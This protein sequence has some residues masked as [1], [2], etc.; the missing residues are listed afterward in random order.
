MQADAK[1]KN[2]AVAGVLALVAGPLGFLYIGWRYA[3]A[4]T[5]VF[6]SFLLVFAILL[7]APPWFKYVNLPAFAFMAYRICERL[8]G[9]VDRGQHRAA[10]EADTW[11][12]AVFAMTSMLPRLAAFD[13]A[14]FGVATAIPRLINGDIGGSLLMLLLV[15]PLFVVVNFVFFVVIATGI[16]RVVM[17]S[18]PAAPRYIF[19]P[20]IALG[21]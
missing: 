19:P 10:L 11:P 4:A 6:L 16:D 5:V 18:V 7:F 9:L 1:E 17:N 15:T 12:V 3:L 8:N 21:K 13:S 14:V 20:A 2:P